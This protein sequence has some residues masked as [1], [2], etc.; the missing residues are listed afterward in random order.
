MM[1]Q[2]LVTLCVIRALAGLGLAVASPA[3]F[4][5]TA[6]SFPRE[7]ERTIA[8]SALALGNPLGAMVGT[9]LGGVTAGLGG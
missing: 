8:F 1:N 7:P 2:D 4:G 3:A 6:V 5:I 9:L